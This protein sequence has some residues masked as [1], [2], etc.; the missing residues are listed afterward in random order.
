MRFHHSLMTVLVGVSLLGVISCKP[1]DNNS[2]L[3]ATDESEYEGY[4]GYGLNPE[5]ERGRR[6][7]YEASGDNARFHTYIVSQKVGAPE[8]WYRVLASKNRDQRWATFGLIQ[9]PDCKPGKE[10]APDWGFD[11][12]KGDADNGGIAPANSEYKALFD[13]V[14]KPGWKDPGCWLSGAYNELDCSLG[15]GTSTGAM[16]YR[17]YPN[18]KFDPENWPGWENYEQAD[19]SI[20]PPFLIGTACGS[21]HITFNPVDPP[22]DPNHPKWRNIKGLVGNQYTHVSEII[23]SGTDPHSLEW[24]SATNARPGTVDTSAHP[25]DLVYNP[26]TINS[27]INL[28][29][30]PP[31]MPAFKGDGFKSF[32][33]EINGTT[34]RV[35]NI[36]KGGEDDVGGAGAILRVYVN[37]GLCAEPCWMN[38]LLDYRTISGRLSEQTAFS[39]AQCRVDC[40]AYRAIEGRYP[41]VITFFLSKA[42]RPTDLKDALYPNEPEDN[43]L[44]KMEADLGLEKI[45]TGRKVFAKN[46]A[47]CHSS[48][49]PPEGQNADEFFADLVRQ[50]DETGDDP[51]LK[52]V[53]GVR[54]DWLGNE[55]REPVTKIGTIRCRALHSNHMRGHVWDEFS[56]DTYKKSPTPPGIPELKGLEGG[57]RGYYR[58][59][60][61]LS[62]WAAAPFMHNNAVGPELCSKL[63]PRDIPCVDRDAVKLDNGK[64]VSITSVEGRIKIYEDSMRAMLNPETRGKKITRTDEDIILPLGPQ[65]NIDLPGALKGIPGLSKL[66]LMLKMF[67]GSE[68]ETALD[69]AKVVIP[70]GTPVSLLGSLDYRRLVKGISDDIASTPLL[71]RPKKLVGL[72]NMMFKDP[73]NL[74]DILKAG[75][76]NSDPNVYSGY[77]NCVDVIEDKGHEF[78]VDLSAEEKDA[79]IAFVKTF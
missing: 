33:K 47:S 22:A 55:E 13:Y 10:G 19:G 70:K 3:R 44:K 30:R 32:D 61:L 62:I 73:S 78:G 18:P 25:T 45:K 39:A 9:D 12:C 36:L 16:G 72:L 26:N 79:L 42:G 23:A 50:A 38:H 52:E 67:G 48:Q 43:R 49:K 65:A 21:C 14:G 8:N 60:S 57:G 75:P 1:R 17:K 54:Q 58:N 7:W 2:G 37:E 66:G 6:V 74:V 34:K 71:Q 28:D 20:E 11:V 68:L 46:C 24:Q 76:A 63:H 77:S 15:L 35:F 31:G 4:E 27:I 53:N 29:R 5:E 56:S 51:F 59:P 41:D 64:T 69:G 40:P